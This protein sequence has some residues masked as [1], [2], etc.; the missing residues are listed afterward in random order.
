MK[1]ITLRKV[2]EGDIEKAF[3]YYLNEA[4]SNLALSFVDTMDQALT[5]I[6]THPLSGSTRLAQY[7]GVEGLRHWGLSRF[8]YTLI[9][10][11]NKDHVDVIRVLHQQS[12]IPLQLGSDLCGIM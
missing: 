8:P 3:I 2:A 6:S 4:G 10:I 11:E 9:Y 7:M 1:P 12:D 5:H